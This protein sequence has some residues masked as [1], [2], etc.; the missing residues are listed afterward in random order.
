MVV[1]LVE[2]AFFAVEV[3][4]FL[5]VVVV[6]VFAVVVFFAV[7]F[8]AV[9]FFVDF[10]LVVFFFGVGMSMPASSV[11]FSVSAALTGITTAPERSAAAAAHIMKLVFITLLITFKI[12]TFLSGKIINYVRDNKTKGVLFFDISL[13]YTNFAARKHHRGTC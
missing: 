7:V 13:F 8:F 1:F 4:A 5:A 12:Y 10:F 2:V 6:V 9:V 3:V 11:R